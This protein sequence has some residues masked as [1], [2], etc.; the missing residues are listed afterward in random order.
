[1]ASTFFRD[2]R[3][4]TAFD[5]VT[6]DSY[7]RSAPESWWVIVTDVVGSTA[8]I[9]TGRYRDVNTVGAMGIAAIQAALP[10]VMFPFAFGGDGASAVIPGD[11]KLIAESV[12]ADVTQLAKTNFQLDLRVGLL[13]VASLIHSGHE[14][15]VGKFKLRNGYPLAVFRG[16]GIKR[17]EELLKSDQLLKPESSP[18]HSADLSQLMCLW[19]PIRSRRGEMLTILVDIDPESTVT[20]DPLSRVLHELQTIFK[21]DVEL[22][23]PINIDAMS[24]QS[25]PALL[26]RERKFQREFGRYLQR[27]L[28][29]VMMWLLCGT[30]LHRVIPSL[31]RYL[32]DFHADSDYRKLEQTLALVLDCTHSEIDEISE[33][34][35][36]LHGEGMIFYGLHRSGDCLMTCFVPSPLQGGHI[37]FVDGGDGGY[38]MAAKAMKAQKALTSLTS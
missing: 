13:S 25:L 32:A 12:L 11:Y 21:G 34:L 38:A 29:A 17:A 37:A 7:F 23:D 20:H 28:I 5:H 31:R 26:N 30:R 18:E 24:F 6:D 27:V 3:S 14:I 4:F 2:L 15:K 19:R 8:A 36:K 22:A 9:E 10:D 1:M 33:V 35:Q 16:Q